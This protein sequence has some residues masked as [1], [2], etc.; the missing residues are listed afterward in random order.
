MLFES[1]M[2]MFARNMIIFVIP[3]FYCSWYVGIPPIF[4]TISYTDTAAYH[5]QVTVNASPL[6][7]WFNVTGR[8]DTPCSYLW[9]T[10]I[11]AKLSYLKVQRLAYGQHQK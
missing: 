11:Y 10:K 2:V 6:K 7:I 4:R 1:Y 5:S 9:T 8:Q 3:D